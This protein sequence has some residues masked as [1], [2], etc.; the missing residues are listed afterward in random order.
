MPSIIEDYNNDIFISY[1]QKDN[2]G[3]RWVS[4][5]VEALKLELDKTFKEEISV[6]FDVNPHDG[7]LETHDVNESLKDKLKCLVFIPMVS[8][9][10]CDPKSFAWEYEFKAFVEQ[11]S[12]DQLGLKVKLTNGNVANRVLPVIIHDL[13]DEDIKLCES[14]L[15]GVLR[16]VEFIYKEPGVN[17][18]LTILD[19]GKKNLSGTRFRNQINKVANAIEEII[20][21]L[22]TDSLDTVTERDEVLLT[23]NIPAGQENSIAVLPFTD[24]SPTKDQDYFCDGVTEEIINAL[25]H[26]KNFKVIARTSAFAFKNKQIDVREI[27]RKLNVETLL[28]GSI[29]KDGNRLRIMA[30][31][32]KVADGSHIWSER[33]DRDMKDV[34]AVQ[35][36]ISMA[37]LDN[38][39]VK[40]LGEKKAMITRRHTENLEAFNLYLKGTYCW[41]MLT[42]EGYKKAAEYFEQALQKDPEYALV[43]V[44]LAAINNVST[45]FGNVP[46]DEA[47]PKANEYINKALKIDDTLAEA[48]SILGHIN[49]FYYWNWKEAERNFNHA[50]QIN[51]NSS[52]IHIYYS[53]LLTC[54]GRHEEAI[55]EAKRAQELDPLSSYINTELALAYSYDGQYDKAIEEYQMTLTINPNYF[56]VHL[57]LGNAYYAKGMIK[58]AIAEI[59][60]AVDLSDGNPFATAA[61]V[62]GYYLIGKKDQAKR[63]FDGLMKKSESEY[64]PP[65]SFY[66]IFSFR[67]EEEKALEWLKKACTDHDTFLPWLRASRIYIPEGSRYLALLKEAG[68]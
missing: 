30:Q 29:R 25:V 62:C 1:R 38:L 46:P 67:G 36:E 42:A 20:S 28:E 12:H 63:L 17:R 64:V 27:G 13:D 6:Y 35:D 39:K 21:G 59:E 31:L 54:T 19:D 57:M 33:Y 24:M 52:L 56:Y 22:K 41:Q 14:V 23:E 48:Y 2:K 34:F 26:I 66:M 18:P 4:D 45:T 53:F 60:E 49:T 44:G 43:Y 55:S 37:I 15:G 10:Y 47:Y 51:P 58:E 16:G 8:R 11:A 7:L 50:L 3:D 9:T 32:I 68:L 40:L 61:L 65:A 5:F